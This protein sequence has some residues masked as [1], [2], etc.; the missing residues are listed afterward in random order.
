MKTKQ[1]YDAPK[2]PSQVGKMK[3]TFQF[4]IIKGIY[5]VL[6]EEVDKKTAFIMILKTVFWNIIF[7][8][9]NWEPGKFTFKD[10]IEEKHYKSKFKELSFFI[11]LFE[12]LKIKYGQEKAQEVTSKIAVPASVPYLAKTF[13][14]I[15][16]I[17]DIDQLRQLMSNYL[18]DGMGFTWTEKVSDDKIEVQ[19]HFTQCVYI[20]ILKT[21][22]LM[23][24][25][26][27][28][29]YCDHIIFDNAMPELYF[30]RDHCKG[31]GDDFCDHLFRIRAPDDAKDDNLRYI[32]TEKADFEAKSLIDKWAKNYKNNGGAFKW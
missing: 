7:N 31:A 24:A 1:F 25:A 8:K 29:C 17:T 12:N 21:Y 9:P 10:K 4:D 22:G 26:A 16:D 5:H 6:A 27:S 28:C 13:K 30:K 3:T 20:E 32:D 19:Y 15:P 11:I 2:L 14:S 18:G 23:S